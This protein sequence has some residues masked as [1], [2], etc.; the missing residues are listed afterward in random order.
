MSVSP[1]PICTPAV[2]AL[3]ANVFHVSETLLAS[4]TAHLLESA[5]DSREKAE[6]PEYWRDKTLPWHFNK[7]ACISYHKTEFLR[8]QWEINGK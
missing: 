3:V 8:V 5:T 2:F 4:M 7:I 1:Q 6:F